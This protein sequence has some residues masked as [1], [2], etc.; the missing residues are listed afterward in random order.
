MER[1]TP[2][3][4]KAWNQAY[5]QEYKAFAEINN[6]DQMLRW[7]YQRFMEDYLRC[8]RSVDDNIGRVLKYL[9]DNGLAENTIIVYMS[10]QGVYLGE[11]GLYDKRFMYE[12]SF[13]TPM[14]IRFP[15]AIRRPQ[16]IDEYVLNLDVPPTLLDFAGV[17]IPPEMQGESMKNLLQTGK[18]RNWRKSLYYHYYERSFG[19]TAHYG[20]RTERYKLI[21][22]YD[23]G[24]SWE[25]YDLQTDPHEMKNLYKD[26]AY[27][28][29]VKELKA[30][31]RTLQKQY[32]DP[33]AG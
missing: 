22:F 7:Q 29:T 20:I 2:A 13:R 27:G 14:L 8:V 26:A 17:A 12:E 4:R 31:L 15:D 23:P 21:H 10:D 32:K 3:E 16:Q 6:E 33:Y 28:E 1:L 25:L 18:E 24:D 11:H 30:K 19:A 5:E 9:D